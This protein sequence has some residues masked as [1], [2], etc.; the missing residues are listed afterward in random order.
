[1]VRTIFVENQR[2]RKQKKKSLLLFEGETKYIWKKDNNFKVHKLPRKVM[3]DLLH[4][5]LL[6][7]GCLH[8]FL[9]LA[10]EGRYKYD[11]WTYERLRAMFSLYKK[12]IYDY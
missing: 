11:L 12:N 4:Y 2:K 7:W 5:F 3:D 8:V 10:R 6:K 9:S 1:M